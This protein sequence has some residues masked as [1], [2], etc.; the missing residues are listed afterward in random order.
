MIDPDILWMA[1]AVSVVA[2]WGLVGAVGSALNR[3]GKW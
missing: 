2:F 1:A 3:R